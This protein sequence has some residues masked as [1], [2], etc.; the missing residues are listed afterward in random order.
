MKNH[1]SFCF[2]WPFLFGFSLGANLGIGQVMLSPVAVTTDI[3]TYSDPKISV[4]NMINHSGVTTPFT[5]GVTIF[6]EYFI[7][8]FHTYATPGNGGTNNWQSTV[9]LDPGIPQGHIDF[10]LSD[11]YQINKLAIANIWC[12]RSSATRR[13]GASFRW[14]CF[15]VRPP[16]QEQD[17]RRT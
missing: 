3:A 11:V 7:D 2:V 16:W 14:R 6:D 10:D 5:N 12:R 17:S 15:P 4:T 9:T 13:S 8:P 1:L